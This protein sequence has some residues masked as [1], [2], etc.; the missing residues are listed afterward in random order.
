[1]LALLDNDEDANRT[2]QPR[3]GKFNEITCSKIPVD[4][5]YTYNEISR[6][7]FHSLMVCN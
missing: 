1:M 7:K 4:Q 3:V 6:N 2:P 5:E